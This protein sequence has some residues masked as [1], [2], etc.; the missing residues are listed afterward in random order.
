MPAATRA[1]VGRSAT[2]TPDPDNPPSS[3][4]EIQRSRSGREVRRPGHLSE[5]QERN[6]ENKATHL[7]HK[8][9]VPTATLRGQPITELR[10][11][12]QARDANQTETQRLLLELVDL[13]EELLN[14]DT[15]HQEE[16]LRRDTQH[17]RELQKLGEA[18]ATTQ[19]ELEEI[20]GHITSTNPSACSYE[21]HSE[22]IQELQSLRSA[23]TTP[24]TASDEP[25]WAAVVANGN[26]TQSILWNT[27][28]GGR[29]RQAKET[30]CIRDKP[31]AQSGDYSNPESALQRTGNTGHPGPWGRNHKNGILDPIPK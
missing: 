21:G 19:R 27:T 9:N 2:R 6:A 4:P 13:R 28:P 23:I 3:P 20:K 1:A 14:R 8:R 31:T 10:D 18:L 5:E 15:Q 24:A 12:N 7:K 11:P 29:K 22:I 30:N 25:S 26:K 16:L 17:Q